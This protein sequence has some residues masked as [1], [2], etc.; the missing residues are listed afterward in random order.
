MSKFIGRV[1]KVG[2]GKESVRGTAV[3]ASYWLPE[4]S[5]SVDDKITVVKDESSIGIIEDGVGQDITSRYSE[6]TLEGRI[7]DLGFGLILKALMG[8]DTKTTASGES[9][10]YDHAFTV[11]QSAQHP[12]LTICV[13]GPNESTGRAYP[14]AMLDQLDLTFELDKYAM[15]KA[16]LRANVSASQSNTPSYTAENAFRP[17]DITIGYASDLSGIGSPTSVAAK[18]VTLSFKKNPEDD[19]TLGNVDPIDRLNKQFSCEG[20]MELFYD[21]RTFI[22]TVMLGD[23]YK[24]I[25]ITAAAP[26]AIGSTSNPTVQITLA[27]VKLSEVAR[28]LDN[29]NI[30]TQTLKFSAFYSISDTEMVDILLRNT[31]SS[32]Y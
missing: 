26:V 9:A 2:I 27:K 4:S 31:V 25:R 6:A 23:L 17:Q 3:S 24:C 18:K 10:V 21:A 12:S 13:A 22:D 30:V 11:Q 29:N 14:L 28:K 20:T 5:L 15:Y 7:T 19:K 32:A 16:Q 1:Y 8:T